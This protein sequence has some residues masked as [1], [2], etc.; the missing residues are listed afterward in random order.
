MRPRFANHNVSR[1]LASARLKALAARNPVAKAKEK[2]VGLQKVRDTLLTAKLR[3]YTFT[4]GE[5]VSAFMS[6]VLQCTAVVGM[7]A[8]RQ[9]AHDMPRE[10]HSD[11]AVLRGGMSAMEQTLRR[12]DS[13]QAV[14]IEQAL[15]RVERLNALLKA[16]HV[17]DAYQDLLA[18]ERK[19]ATAAT[20]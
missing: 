11:L 5:D 4:D 3:V 2:S 19:Y 1:G 17:F 20:S 9:W 6:G 8:E 10:V 16:E 12:W 18:I 7:A 14:A 13:A 15:E